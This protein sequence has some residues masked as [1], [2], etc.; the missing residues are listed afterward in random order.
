MGPGGELDER[1]LGHVTASVVM[2]KEGTEDRLLLCARGTVS[3][4]QTAAL[5]ASCG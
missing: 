2:N 1:G 4:A 5:V 3:W